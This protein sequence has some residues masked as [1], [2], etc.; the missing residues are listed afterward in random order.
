MDI[1]AL[2]ESMSS[3]EKQAFKK[4]FPNESE[5]VRLYDYINRNKNYNT[6]KIKIFL[7]K[8]S[9]KDIKKYTSGYL[10]VIKNYLKEKI[11]E[12]LRLQLIHKR[13]SYEIMIRSLNSEILLE[14]GLIEMANKELKK[15]KKIGGD[16]IFPTEQIFILRSESILSYYQDYQNLSFEELMLLYDKRQALADH[17]KIET[18][19]VRILSIMGYCHFNHLDPAIYIKKFEST[20][21]YQS[22]DVLKGLNFE[23][24]YLLYWVKSLLAEVKQQPLKAVAYFEKALQVW[25]DKPELIEIHPRM[26]LAACFSYLKLIQKY[27]SHEKL[28]LKKQSFNTFLKRLD[29]ISLAE[30][31]KYTYRIIVL[32]YQLFNYKTDGLYHLIEATI[33]KINELLSASNKITK[34]TD[35]SFRYYVAFGLYQLGKHEEALDWINPIFHNEASK[36]KYNLGYIVDYIL[37]YLLIHFQLGNYRFLQYELKKKINLLKKTGQW[38]TSPL[39]FFHSLQKFIKKPYNKLQHE[40]NLLHLEQYLN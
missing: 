19:L 14:K 30:D 1:I 33:P 5:F 32:L 12:C 2:V 38:T 20:E 7:A 34:Y 22:E 21:L 10:S 23:N 24:K 37:L 29:S 11:L 8:K 35:S 13:P 40:E 15:A 9:G 4:L 3:S 39:P 6:D 18:T 26:Y 36:T 17:I 25:L 31:E 27:S 28:V 16:A